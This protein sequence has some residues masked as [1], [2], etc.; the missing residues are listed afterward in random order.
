M[1]RF[2]EGWLSERDVRAG[3]RMRLFCLPHAGSGAAAYYRWKQ[4]LEGVDVCPVLLP[5]REIRLAERSIHDAVALVETLLAGISPY[6]DVPFAV[7]G[8]SMGALL[9]YEWALR[10]EPFCLFVS[11]RDAAHLPFGHRELHR[12]DDGAFVAELRRRYGGMPDDFLADA[13]LREVFL[14]ILRADLRLVETYRHGAERLL[15]CPVMAFAG[16]DD[17]SV[18]DAGLTGWGELTRGEFAAKRFEGDHFYHSGAG[19]AELLEAIRERLATV[20]PLPPE[21]MQS[22]SE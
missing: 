14:P 20:H 18:S 7:F 12:L 2:A 22:T 6:L 19:Q 5:G 9:A 1:G 21:S 16:R 3:A 8:H 15:D 4:K 10:K 17:T 13:E 11:G